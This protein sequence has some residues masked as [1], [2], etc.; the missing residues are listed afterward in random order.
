MATNDPSK[1]T[2]PIKKSRLGRGLGSLLGDNP[3]LDVGME[4][5]VAKP[6]AMVDVIERHTSVDDKKYRESKIWNIDVEKLVANTQQP[7]KYFEKEKL[8]EL[9][10][11]IRQHGVLNPIVASKRDDGGFE[12]IA[13]ERRWRA[14]QLAGL[15]Q[16]P[17]ILRD[18]EA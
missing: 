11:S 13:G 14:S 1:P 2:T 17:V 7:R 18:V 8:E 15:K 16:V 10:Q 6:D 12:I 3:K 4:V 9:A 5:E